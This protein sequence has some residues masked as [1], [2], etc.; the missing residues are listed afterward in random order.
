M[1]KQKL[2]SCILVFL[3]IILVKTNNTYASKQRVFE[4]D[5]KQIFM[6][7]NKAMLCDSTEFYCGEIGDSFEWT[8]PHTFRLVDGDYKYTSDGKTK[9]SSKY[10]WEFRSDDDNQ[11]D[12]K[13]AWLA[14]YLYDGINGISI[15]RGYKAFNDL[16]N[17]RRRQK[18]CNLASSILAMAKRWKRKW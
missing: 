9:L 13:M 15:N 16:L 4:Y 6:K 1:K 2:I 7:M 14:K 17:S 10:Y 3:I 18:L 5:T 12:R 8:N 11:T